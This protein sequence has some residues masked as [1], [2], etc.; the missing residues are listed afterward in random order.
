MLV[1]RDDVCT[2]PWCDA[3]IAH[4]DHPQPVRD[5]GPTD[6]RNGSGKCA[7]CNHV[8]EAPG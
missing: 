1:L 5:S 8:K 4:A 2:T 6:W 7:R 3:P